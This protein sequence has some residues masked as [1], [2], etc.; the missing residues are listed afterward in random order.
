VEV[1]ERKKEESSY[2]IGGSGSDQISSLNR[3]FF[4][5]SWRCAVFSNQDLR[6][7]SA[8]ES[9]GQRSIQGA[10]SRR[11]SA[12]GRGIARVDASLARAAGS[13]ARAWRS[14]SV[15]T[16]AGP[17]LH[18]A[19]DRL[20][21]PSASLALQKFS[22]GTVQA[23]HV[24]R[25]GPIAT[26]CKCQIRSI[27]EK[28]KNRRA[29]RTPDCRDRLS[30]GASLAPEPRAVLL[31][32]AIAPDGPAHLASAV[33]SVAPGAIAAVGNARS[34]S[35]DLCGQARTFTQ[36]SF[37]LSVCSLVLTAISTATT[38]YQ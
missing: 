25:Q 27:S 37:V 36:F 20:A 8:G 18:L 24:V 13:L 22:S 5:Y 34:T 16:W 9:K 38:Q 1:Q 31:V 6:S 17:L 30:P 35:D 2:R 23:V 7:D 15:A 10:R 26:E 19:I 3:F 21:R 11:A 29:I 28:K 4:P 33:R 32:L 12:P 14:R